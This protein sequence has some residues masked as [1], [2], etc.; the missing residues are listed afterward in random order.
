[1]QRILGQQH[2]VPSLF[3]AY[4]YLTD[5]GRVIVNPSAQISLFH[6]RSMGGRSQYSFQCNTG[7]DIRIL[8]AASM[9]HLRRYAFSCPHALIQHHCVEK[10]QRLAN[11]DKAHALGIAL[12]LEHRSLA[13]FAGGFAPVLVLNLLIAFPFAQQCK[14]LLALLRCDARKF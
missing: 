4:L 10:H 7:H 11:A 1:M 14:T 8:A 5:I 6:A 2:N 12:L 9:R 3:G 13:P